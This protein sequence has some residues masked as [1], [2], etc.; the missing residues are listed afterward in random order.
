[1]HDPSIARTTSTNG[2]DRNVPALSKR[3]IR[4]HFEKRHF[5]GDHRLPAASFSQF[6][7]PEAII[8]DNS[9][10]FVSAE[11]TGFLTWLGIRHS[12]SSVYFPQ[13]N[14]LI[15]R[16]HSTLKH[17]LARV[18][19]NA[20]KTLVCIGLRLDNGCTT[21]AT[22]CQPLSTTTTI[23]WMRLMRPTKKFN[24]CKIHPRGPAMRLRLRQ[25]NDCYDHATN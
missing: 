9:T 6:G 8:L 15:E 23:R 4:V 3:P 22:C 18:R 12:R 13:A 10:P 21:K 5:E 14:G 19:E 17:S 20:H 25:T 2:S 7:L 1:M 24:R 16:F 11:F